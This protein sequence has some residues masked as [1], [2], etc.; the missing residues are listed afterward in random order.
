MI[1]VAHIMCWLPEKYIV[2]KDTRGAFGKI[3]SPLMIN[4]YEGGLA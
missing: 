2:V 1:D 4:F 3:Q